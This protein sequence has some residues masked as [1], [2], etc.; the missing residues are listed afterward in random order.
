MNKL[1]PLLFLLFFTC[2]KVNSQNNTSSPYS[3]YG[4][5][6][7]DFKGT[8]ENRAMG[9]LSVYNDSIH[10][11]FKN[12]ASYTGK[13]MFSFNNE[14]RLVKFTVGL[15]HTET[16]LKTSS[17][18]SETANTSFE[19]LGLNIP[20][21][22][23]GLGFGL[24]PYSSVGYKLESLNQ[25]NEIQFQYTGKGGLNKTFLGFAY[26]LSKNIAIGFDTRYN[27][28]NIQNSA[29][30]YLY[31]EESLPLDYHAREQNRSDLSGINYN[32]GI[33]YIGN[34]N[35]NLELHAS[36]AH[37]PEYNLSSRNT[38]TFASVVINPTTLIEYPVNEINVDLESLSLDRTDL[39]MP[40]R[41][42][43][44]AGISKP[45]KWFLGVEY[46]LL[47]SSVFS[48]DLISIENSEFEDSSKISLGGF[49][50]PDYASFSK[51]WKRVVYRGGLYTEKTGLVINNE[52]I[53]EFGIS[54]GLGIPAGGLFSNVNTTIEFGKRGTTNEN[55]V[56]ENFINFQL[57]LSLN[58]RWFI[59]RK[60]N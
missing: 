16:D 20:M 21:G 10:M 40:S 31:D 44:G 46:T 30:E 59:E 35:E 58:D 23:F 56:E 39:S 5:G 2:Y 43:F 29:L 53:N 38:R 32:F 45:K 15:G 27:F 50:I 60:Y 26:Q 28:G 37:S 11:N 47:G 1:F 42:T 24:I 48:N 8:S 6:S 52:S 9:G 17:S 7:L 55:L 4:I 13:N 33:T 36:V 57:S 22:K 25:E 54:F 3:F 49:Y 51:F 34:L 41:T 12:P 14:G 18:N 19:Y